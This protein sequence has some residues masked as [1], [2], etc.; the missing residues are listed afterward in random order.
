MAYFIGFALLFWAAD[1]LLKAMGVSFHLGADEKKR[2]P[3]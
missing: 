3:D 2:S 1:L